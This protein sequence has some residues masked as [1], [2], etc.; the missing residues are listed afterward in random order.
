MYKI[1]CWRFCY[2]CCRSEQ[3][4][5]THTESIFGKWIWLLRFEWLL[6]NKQ[7]TSTER[8]G[9]KSPSINYILFS[10]PCQCTTQM[11]GLNSI[12]T[13]RN[14]GTESKDEKKNETTHNTQFLMI[15]CFLAIYIRCAL[16]FCN[17]N[18]DFSIAIFVWFDF[19]LCSLL[20]FFLRMCNC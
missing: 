14:S 12:Y 10:V 11:L 1:W 7:R 19:L 9:E 8:A 13:H 2:S 17:K 18:S 3:K 5:H 4:K 16:S 6:E 20:L 15:D